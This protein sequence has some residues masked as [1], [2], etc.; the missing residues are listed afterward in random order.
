MR[1]RNSPGASEASGVPCLE[2]LPP[3]GRTPEE[4]FYT[5][6]RG[7]ALPEP[8]AALHPLLEEPEGLPSQLPD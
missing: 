7:A 6:L 8:V 2:S 5:V 3:A 4:R 1:S